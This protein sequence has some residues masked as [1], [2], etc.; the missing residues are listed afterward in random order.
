M[1]LTGTISLLHPYLED[2][3]PPI[4]SLRWKLSVLL[5]LKFAHLSNAVYLLSLSRNQVT[6]SQHKSTGTN[7]DLTPGVQQLNIILKGKRDGFRLENKYPLRRYSFPCSSEGEKIVV[8][9]HKS[10]IF[11]KYLKVKT[12]SC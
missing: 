12:K 4:P 5:A 1:P 11:R 8:I 7:V 6:P 3:M 10:S 9:Q 2:S